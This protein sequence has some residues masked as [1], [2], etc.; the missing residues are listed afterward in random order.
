[1]AFAVTQRTRE[2]GVRMALGA[3]R[4]RVLGAVLGRGALV[5]AIGLALGLTAAV[6]ATRALETL[7]FGIGLADPLTYVGV[8]ALLAA[9]AVL[10][11]WSP[12]RRA[13]RVEPVIAMRD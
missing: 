10:A 7:L 13:S 1:M 9:T 12:A 5:T 11:C 6:F 2:I 3:G 4:A 8:A